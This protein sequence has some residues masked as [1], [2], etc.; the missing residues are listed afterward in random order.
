VV[1]FVFNC[2]PCRGEVVEINRHPLDY[3]EYLVQWLNSVS[4]PPPVQWI[5]VSNPPPVQWISERYIDSVIGR[6]E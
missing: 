6:N 2:M 4:N 5:S 3:D 1:E